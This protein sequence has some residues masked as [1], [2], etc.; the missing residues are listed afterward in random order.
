MYNNKLNVE[1]R[2]G[3]EGGGGD[4][5]H[6]RTTGSDGIGNKGEEELPLLIGLSKQCS[7]DCLPPPAAP[8]SPP[9]PLPLLWCIL[10]L[11]RLAVCS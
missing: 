6:W 8:P 3:G 5:G 7:F 9:P 10:L 2:R 11:I 4:I 1:L